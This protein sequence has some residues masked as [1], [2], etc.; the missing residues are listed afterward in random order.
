MKQLDI[1]IKYMYKSLI[2]KQQFSKFFPKLFGKLLNSSYLCLSKGWGYSSTYNK[3]LYSP[4]G[5]QTEQTTTM[6]NKIQQLENLKKYETLK[7]VRL[8]LE[9]IYSTFKL[10]ENQENHHYNNYDIFE[11]IASSLTDSKNLSRKV[12]SVVHYIWDDSVEKLYLYGIS[13][14]VMEDITQTELEEIFQLILNK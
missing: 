3:N 1:K 2:I 7:D 11:D 9:K 12:E 5:N 10:K 6:D 13:D 14:S 8:K 4:V